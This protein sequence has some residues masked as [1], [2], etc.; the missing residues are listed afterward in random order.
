MLLVSIEKHG[1]CIRTL[2]GPIIQVL[3]KVMCPSLIWSYYQNVDG[4]S[5]V[6]ESEKPVLLASANIAVGSNGELHRGVRT[7]T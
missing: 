7:T 5:W 1:Y 4:S 2:G 3:R 6:G